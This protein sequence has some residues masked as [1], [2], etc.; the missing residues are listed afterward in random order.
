MK[1]KD[2]ILLFLLE[3]EEEENVKHTRYKK[4]FYK[5]LSTFERQRRYRCIPRQ[6]L[7]DPINCAWQQ[8]CKSKNDGALITLTGFDFRAFNWLSKLFVLAYN[9]THLMSVT[10]DTLSAQMILVDKNG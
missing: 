8:L 4:N 9:S 3:E 1:M 2:V 6:S 5:L 7:H 10:M